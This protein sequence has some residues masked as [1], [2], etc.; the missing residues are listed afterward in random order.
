MD[1]EIDTE[2]S[3]HNYNIQVKSE[4]N[5]HGMST[6]NKY[7]GTEPSERYPDSKTSDGSDDYNCDIESRET[8]QNFPNVDINIK[9]E[10][11]VYDKSHPS[12]WNAI[13]STEDSSDLYS[14]NNSVPKHL[15]AHT[16][17]SFILSNKVEYAVCIKYEPNSGDEVESTSKGNPSKPCVQNQEYQDTPDST[18]KSPCFDNSE[19]INSYGDSGCS[20]SDPRKYEI[21]NR[22]VQQ[23]CT[24][25][26]S[27]IPEPS[28]PEKTNECGNS[29]SRSIA[30]DEDIKRKHTNEKLYKCDVCSYS[31]TRR[32]NLLSHKRKHT[33]EKSGDICSHSTSLPRNIQNVAAHKRKHTGKKQYKCVLCSYS[34]VWRSALARHKRTHKQEKPFKC[35]VCSYK[36]ATSEDLARHRLDTLERSRTSV[37]CVVT[38]L[39]GPVL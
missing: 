37:M 19:N 8:T 34:N 7:A 26:K 21:M 6:V 36:S 14:S 24:S 13:D 2:N 1:E 17:P 25:I 27:E 15:N 35:D 29:T 22:N 31:T 18:Q 38:A 32:N 16:R 39:F 9:E 28:I 4:P 30:L 3:I 33:V 23:K 10:P 12:C 20:F 11:N 5:L